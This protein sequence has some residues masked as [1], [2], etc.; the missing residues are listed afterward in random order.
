M[1]IASLSELKRELK[2]LSEEDMLAVCLRLARYKKDNKEL[3]HYLLLEAQDE[4]A[5]IDLI[6]EDIEEGFETINE[7][8][9][10]YAK[11]GIRKVL[12]VATKHIR[13]SGNKQTEVEVLLYFCKHIINM[14]NPIHQS[15]V[16]VNLFNN[17]VKKIEKA[18][19]YLHE[20]LQYD[21][22]QEL[23]GLKDWIQN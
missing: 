8:N 9:L 7:S 10:Y 12:R 6:K 21:Y 11:K 19:S 18:L 17:Q 4:P 3:L 14:E 13:Y 20:D 23:E 16:L 1:Q 5:Y 15:K 2:L 22:T